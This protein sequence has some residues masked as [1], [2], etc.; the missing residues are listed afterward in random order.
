MRLLNAIGYLQQQ[1]IIHADLKPENLML[2]KSEYLN[3]LCCFAYE[4]LGQ[5]NIFELCWLNWWLQP[6]QHFVSDSEFLTG[7]MSTAVWVCEP[8]TCN[9]SA[10]TS[11]FRRC[12]ESRITNT[13]LTTACWNKCISTPGNRLSVFVYHQAVQ[14]IVVWSCLT[15]WYTAIIHTSK[16]QRNMAQPLNS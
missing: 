6:L 16:T 5:E 4:K 11:S 12:F 10:E 9:N 3:V 13:R 7:L 8:G 1:N 14:A 15:T 2:Q